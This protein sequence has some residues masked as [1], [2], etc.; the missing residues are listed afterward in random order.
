MKRILI[1][2]IV[3]SA[4]MTMAADSPEE[5]QELHTKGR[6]FLNANDVANGRE[7]TLKAAEMRERLF[8]KLSKEYIA[9]LNNYALSYLISGE[10]QKALEYQTEVVELCRRMDPPHP[11]EGMYLINLGRIHHA[12]DNY[13]EA[14]RLMEEALPKVEKFS[15]N[16]EY[17]L[18]FLGTVYLDRNDNANLNRILALAEEHSEENLKKDCNDPECHLERAEYFAVTGRPALAKDEYMAV[19]ALPLSDAQKVLAYRK[20]AVFLI[21]QKDFPQAA[22]YYRMA[23][24]AAEAAEGVS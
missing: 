20:Y 16:Y 17:I 2:A 6:E 13:D 7:Y 12:L 9:S 14:G 3:M 15:D 21:E 22:E 18:T 4:A 8:G 1:S 24:E 19:F 5:A 11:D 10:P 23:S